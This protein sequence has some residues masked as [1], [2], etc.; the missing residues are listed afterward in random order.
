MYRSITGP[1]YPFI[2]VVQVL[3][4]SRNSGQIS[5][6]IDTG[7]PWREPAEFRHSHFMSGIKKGEEQGD[8]HSLDVP[9]PEVINDAENGVLIQ[10]H[11][12]RPSLSIRSKTPFRKYLGTRG[13]GLSAP[14]SKAAS[15]GLATRRI[16]RTSSKPAVVMS[17]T[18]APLPS[19]MALVPMV[20]PWMM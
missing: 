17:P 4:Y 2:T 18:L 10:R 3:S 1:R 16:S 6:E 13:G 8:D 11:D 15:F 14:K 12:D 9:L 7:M 5:E 20:V 19:T